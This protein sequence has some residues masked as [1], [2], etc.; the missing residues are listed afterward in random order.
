MVST[1]PCRARLERSV[2]TNFPHRRIKQSAQ[3]LNSMSGENLFTSLILLEN[4][5]E[6]TRVYV[7]PIKPLC[8][9]LDS[10]FF[11]TI[12]P[13]HHHHHH[14][15]TI[16]TGATSK[17]GTK[18]SANASTAS[19]GK[20]P[21][22]ASSS[23]PDYPDSADDFVED[24]FDEYLPPRARGS[25]GKRTSSKNPLKVQDFVARTPETRSKKK[26]IK[27]KMEPDSP[28]K[29]PSASARS[30]HGGSGQGAGSSGLSSSSQPIFSEQ[31]FINPA[32]GTSGGSAGAEP[33]SQMT[34][35]PYSEPPANLEVHRAIDRMADAKAKEMSRKLEEDFAKETGDTSAWMETTIDN[36]NLD[37]T[38]PAEGDQGLETT[39]PQSP[40]PNLG[41][42]PAASTP[43]RGPNPGTTRTPTRTS[44]RRSP[45]NRKEVTSSPGKELIKNHISQFVGLARKKA[46]RETIREE[47]ESTAESD[48]DASSE[49][50]VPLEKQHSHFGQSLAK[51]A[52][53][54]S[55]PNLGSKGISGQEPV[56]LTSHPF[57]KEFF[58]APGQANELGA[59]SSGFPP[60]NPGNLHEKSISRT[61][62]QD[63]TFSQERFLEVSS[64]MDSGIGGGLTPNQSHSGSVLDLSGQSQKPGSL[65]VT[66]KLNQP[67]SH[68][69]GLEGH[70]EAE[71]T[72]AQPPSPPP[73]PPPALP[74]PSAMRLAAGGP[75]G[76]ESPASSN[77]TEV[78]S[79]TVKGPFKSQEEEDEEAMAFFEEDKKM[80]TPP[81]S[82][83][84]E[85]MEHDAIALQE[86]VAEGAGSGD[87]NNHVVAI[88]NP[89]QLGAGPSGSGST[90]V[91]PNPNGPPGNLT[92][93]SQSQD[94]VMSGDPA[95]EGLY[96]NGTPAHQTT[97]VR[98]T[99]VVAA[100]QLR[101]AVVVDPATGQTQV[102]SQTEQR[103][104]QN[105][106]SSGFQGHPDSRETLASSHS[107]ITTYPAQYLPTQA[108]I[109]SQQQ[110][111]HPPQPSP[112]IHPIQPMQPVQP[113]YPNPE[114]PQFQPQPHPNQN[115]P[116]FQQPPP[117]HQSQQHP[118]NHQFQQPPPNHYHPGR[119]DQNQSHNI[120]THNHNPHPA[121]PESQ[122]NHLNHPHPHQDPS[123]HGIQH[124]PQ[125]LL[126]PP[127]PPPPTAQNQLYPN[128][129][130]PLVREDPR[131]RHR[132][133]N[134]N[135]P[136]NPATTSSTSNHSSTHNL[137]KGRR[138]T[139]ADSDL[140]KQGSDRKA[141]AATEPAATSGGD[142]VRPAAAGLTPSQPATVT[143]EVEMKDVNAS[144][145][146]R[147]DSNQP[148]AAPRTDD[149]IQAATKRLIS[150]P[151][152]E[153]PPPERDPKNP[154][155]DFRGLE[156]RDLDVNAMKLW[157]QS[158]RIK[159]FE[160]IFG[161]RDPAADPT[162]A[163]EEFYRE[164]GYRRE[165]SVNHI[166]AAL[167]NAWTPEVAEELLKKAQVEGPEQDRARLC[168]LQ[169]A[170]D[171]LMVPAMQKKK[172]L[173]NAKGK[174]K[175]PEEAAAV[176]RMR[177]IQSQM[178]KDKKDTG[179]KK[180]GKS[181]PQPGPSTSS[182][183]APKPDNAAANT[184][185]QKPSAKSTRPLARQPSSSRDQTAS[186]GRGDYRTRGQQH[187]ERGRGGASGSR[188]RG[189]DRS[190]SE[191][192]RRHQT[193][194]S[195]QLGRSQPPSRQ[196]RHRHQ[197]RRDKSK[198]D[199]N[200]RNDSSNLN[201]AQINSSSEVAVSNATASG[202]GSSHGQGSRAT[203][204]A[205]ATVTTSS[206]GASASGSG[207]QSSSSS[208]EAEN[209]ADHAQT[210]S[211]ES[212][213]QH[214]ESLPEQA[215]AARGGD[216]GPQPPVATDAD[217]LR[218][219]VSGKSIDPEHINIS[220]GEAVERLIPWIGR[221]VESTQRGTAAD[222][223]GLRDIHFDFGRIIIHP[224]SQE[225]GEWIAQAIRTRM[226]SD[227]HPM[228]FDCEW[229]GNLDP[230][231]ELTVKTR[232]M[233]KESEEEVRKLIEAENGGLCNLNIAL[234][235]WPVH[236]AGG[237]RFLRFWDEHGYRIIKF[238][239]TKGVV[240]AIMADPHR[241]KVYIGHLMGTVRHE[242]S[243]VVPGAEIAYR[244]QYSN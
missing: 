180:A 227:N 244:R 230:V 39:R 154:Q 186:K 175:T 56:C 73:P 80:T 43:I 16:M 61:Q 94:V 97:A 204:S 20:P 89:D 209:P 171:K 193:P 101:E 129:F 118:P 151:A 104:I 113:Y 35:K 106:A 168:L 144:T 221:E 155:Y 206:A 194:A 72:S 222:Q 114:I 12:S 131:P 13:H 3:I 92:Q 237:T 15:T 224:S 139:L 238:I 48:V 27:I 107:H 182:S 93:M 64:G 126:A 109:V 32:S 66:I 24:D 19:Q 123:G 45:R 162:E 170:I 197:D 70:V 5:R 214:D 87:G 121:H 74:I 242:R 88:F 91:V 166:M 189:R 122:P 77:V 62:S 31:S 8:S 103:I 191:H 210:F 124:H 243:D 98:V 185:T 241:G 179:T 174:K 202:Q 25:R 218:L 11:L 163:T 29:S 46:S 21:Q 9:V 150:V 142:G 181:Q 219:V 47:A 205:T 234:C 60:I 229:N 164:T 68:A 165:L 90:A 236:L 63:R 133:P 119:N 69:I 157:N 231:A 158:V 217:S 201:N 22:A 38:M 67:S 184:P 167:R 138:K 95:E 6:D 58:G 137:Y 216:Q 149:S 136:N 71:S 26:T 40:S 223:V 53:N 156:Q 78:L 196:D 28:T 36:I 233:G 153:K 160:I 239:A 145:T 100:Q 51:P 173:R 213:Q 198:S 65:K 141:E 226:Q 115:Q 143:P 134:P 228:G 128:A 161:T 199:N 148:P 130:P 49:T 120:H 55:D 96:S 34:A 159:E 30:S 177:E 188:G 37:T 54:S 152:G 10:D 212:I 18:K 17:K 57:T 203:A 83:R 195:D 59:E 110:P 86:A 82:E 132:Q 4:F 112:H 79:P 147:S 225:G 33:G 208:R 169:I 140:F 183:S 99:E 42:P 102:I 41:H 215:G 2:T 84:V 135:D 176:L 76:L 211:Q 192:G 232:A 200:S 117:N 172:G 111:P 125:S 235:G 178:A 50:V 14:Q 105:N 240:E 7:K 75:T 146:D 108:Q 44:P 190:R 116:Q 207:T 220:Q 85:D 23:L 127:P 1:Q 187:G 81:S 52:E